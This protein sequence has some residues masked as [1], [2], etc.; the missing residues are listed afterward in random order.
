MEM[1]GDFILRHLQKGIREID[2]REEEW[3]IPV[4]IGRRGRVISVSSPTE[5]ES[6]HRTPPTPAPLRIDFYGL[7]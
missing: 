4:S 2:R 7:K 5:Q 1:E 6:P 3:S